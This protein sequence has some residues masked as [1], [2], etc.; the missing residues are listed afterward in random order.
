MSLVTTT[1]AVKQIHSDCFVI[2][3]ADIKGDLFLIFN[4]MR[5]QVYALRSFV[6]F[7]P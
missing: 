1:Q 4:R 3:I 7:E 2:E 6:H 5:L